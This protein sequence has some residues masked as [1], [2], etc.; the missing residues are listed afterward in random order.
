MVHP[1]GER[2][3]VAHKE[4]VLDPVS[5]TGQALYAESYDPQRPVVC[6]DESSTQLLAETR[7]CLPAKPGRPR[8]E[9]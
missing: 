7:E 3:L 6:F 5:S 8:R 1:Q 2:R 4:D 9:G